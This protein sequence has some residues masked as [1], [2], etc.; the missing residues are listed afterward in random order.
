[1]PHDDRTGAAVLEPESNRLPNPDAPARIEVAMPR[2]LYDRLTDHDQAPTSRYETATGRAEFVAEP[3][4]SHEW[5]PAKLSALFEEIGRLLDE[6]G[7]PAQ[8]LAAGAS[9]LLSDDGAFEPDTCL[10]LDPAQALAAMRVDGYLDTRAGDPVPDIVVEI[11]RSVDSRGKLGPYFR[12]GVREV[13]TWSRADGARIW[14]ADAAAADGCAPADR[15]RA[16]P[17]LDRTALDRLLASR[18]PLDASRRARDVA[19]QV[20]DALLAQ[21]ACSRSERSTCR[22]R[23]PARPRASVAGAAVTAGG[24]QPPAP[25]AARP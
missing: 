19:R 18:T 15:S 24:L 3:G 5:R 7:R 2:G 8:L 11:D 17:G 20:A 10:F 9:R 12:M 4:V 16:L 6:A 25:G 1:M 13:W 23:P 21:G 14:S 22:V